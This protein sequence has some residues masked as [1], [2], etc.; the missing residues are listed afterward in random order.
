MRTDRIPPRQGSRQNTAKPVKDTKSLD[1]STMAI[2]NIKLKPTVSSHIF[3]KPSSDSPVTSPDVLEQS[4][5][6]FNQLRKG[7]NTSISSLT[8]KQPTAK[9]VPSVDPANLTFAERR[10]LMEQTK[11]TGNEKTNSGVVGDGGCVQSAASQPNAASANMSALTSSTNSDKSGCLDDSKQTSSDVDSGGSGGSFTQVPALLPS[12]DKKMPL[13]SPS[14]DA[15]ANTVPSVP[16]RSASQAMPPAF[17]AK[18]PKSPVSQPASVVTAHLP[19]VPSITK[20]SLSPS[21]NLIKLS[22]T[23]ATSLH[24]GKDMPAD[25]ICMTFCRY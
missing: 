5:F 13:P 4:P 17:I 23:P 16:N 7:L 1:I 8:N 21:Q 14:N 24:Q 22:D 15:S 19:P 12:R 10:K 3:N 11:A 9:E 2:K 20:T 6:M 25:N 18:R